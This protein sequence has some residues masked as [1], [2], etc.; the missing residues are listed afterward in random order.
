MTREP[1]TDYFHQLIPT[2][3]SPVV[4]ASA[5]PRRADLFTQVGLQFK[6]VPSTINEPNPNS[7]SDSPAVIAEHLAL[8]K[9]RDVAAHFSE[10]WIIGADTVVSYQHQ[11]LGK[12]DSP[13]KACE[14]LQTLSGKIHEVT[15]GV[16]LVSVSESRIH[17]FSETTQVR[18]R[19]LTGE[20]IRKY[21]DTGE[22]MDKAGAYGIQGKGALFVS[23]IQGD[24]NNVVGFP[25]TSFYEESIKFFRS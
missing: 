8:L 23:A 3:P 21:V 5:S 18:F 25:L 15:T 24:Y 12:P 2:I 7:L 22:P 16:A 10:G 9:A 11:L 4:L 14:M 13:V 6:V 17:T 20:E 1:L 19:E